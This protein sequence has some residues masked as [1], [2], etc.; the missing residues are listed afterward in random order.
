MLSGE[1]LGLSLSFLRPGVG[2][3]HLNTGNSDPETGQGNSHSTGQLPPEARNPRMCSILVPKP[4]LF[5]CFYIA[6]GTD[7]PS[8]PV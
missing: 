1:L 4:S 5:M 3:T 2:F 6:E 7:V 8:P